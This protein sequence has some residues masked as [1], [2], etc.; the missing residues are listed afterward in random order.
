VA[1]STAVLEDPKSSVLGLK[2]YT[3]PVLYLTTVPFIYFLSCTRGIQVEPGLGTFNFT[4]IKRDDSVAVL[5]AVVSGKCVLLLMGGAH[6]A[7][8]SRDRSS[9]MAVLLGAW[10]HHGQ[11]HH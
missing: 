3:G 10:N 11:D 8:Q 6:V 7:G 9:K 1:T 2:I 5:H 4:S